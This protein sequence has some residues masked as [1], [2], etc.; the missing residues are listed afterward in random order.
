MNELLVADSWLYS[1]LLA[2]PEV[3]ALVST[4]IYSEIAPPKA[5]FPYLIFT[6]VTTSDIQSFN[7]TVIGAT[8][9][10]D[11]RFV[12]EAKTFMPANDAYEALHDQLHRKTLSV[13]NGNIISCVRTATIRFAEAEESSGAQYRHLGGTYRIQ[14]Q[15]V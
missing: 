3:A 5:T 8:A 6:M 11:I 9:M 2:T 1:T 13:P 12:A 4:R 10:Y 14:V 7:A 15:G